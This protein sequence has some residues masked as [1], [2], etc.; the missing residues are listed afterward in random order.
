MIFIYLILP[1]I[2]ILSPILYSARYYLNLFR[3]LRLR[4]ILLSI[5]FWPVFI[6]A[7]FEYL[8][9]IIVGGE[10]LLPPT[11]LFLRNFIVSLVA[12]LVILI[13]RLISRYLRV[14][15]LPQRPEAVFFT[16]FLAGNFFYLFIAMIIFTWIPETLAIPWFS[17]LIN[18]LILVSLIVLGLI[19]VWL[20][21]HYD[22]LA[23]PR[24][25]HYLG[26]FIFLY[27]I[28]L[29][30]SMAIG[31]PGATIIGYPTLLILSLVT[32]A[33]FIKLSINIG[34]FSR[35]DRVKSLLVIGLL[36]ASIFIVTSYPLKV[37]GSI[38][39]SWNSEL[40]F[41]IDINASEFPIDV[42]NIRLVDRELA[43]DFALS[44]RLPRIGNYQLEV[45][46]SYENIGLIMGKPAWVVP[47]YY[48]YAFTPEINYM[49]GYLYIHLD[50]PTFE[51]M[52]F[53]S[54]EMIIA[55]GL[56][57]KR[58]LFFFT[59]KLVPDG[60]IG[61]IYLIDPS[62][63]TTS[64]AWVVLVDKYTS[65]G[66]R[67]P[68]KVL[69][70]GAEGDY[71]IFNWRNA[72]GLVPQVVSGAALE[73]IIGRIGV[74]IRNGEKDYFA[75]GFIWIPISQ[76]IQEYLEDE[77]YHR[78]HHFLLGNWWGRDFYLAVRTTGGEESVATWI[79]VN[80]T[81]TLFD[82][83]FYRGIGGIE[84]GVNAPEKALETME[85]IIEGKVPYGAEVRYPKL[86]RVSIGRENYLVWVALVV[87]KLPGA[88]KPIGVVWVDASNP[89]IAGFVQYVYGESHDVF[90]DRLHNNI[91]ASY[92]GWQGGNETTLVTTLINGTII[93]KNWALLQPNNEFAIIMSVE[94]ISGQIVIV[95][96]LE[97]KVATKQDF[98][99][100]VLA[101]EGDWVEIEARWDIELQAWVAYTVKLYPQEQQP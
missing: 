16:A 85:G 31:A 11:I 91:I 58:D 8:S 32:I 26:A 71:V 39:D 37:K 68:Y 21:L 7:L 87:Q 46:T 25:L 97:T 48:A 65:W 43:K 94:N 78:S 95:I 56:Y 54:K 93:R 59:L 28:T 15:I 34:L 61:E 86:Y 19:I 90:M 55:P 72:V 3:G 50:T 88:D 20:A 70:V 38:D 89:R 100:A 30:V 69:I 10:I 64:P 4:A 75:R 27:I 29:A 40:S 6:I 1:L 53:I 80:S 42:D 35:T 74:S 23:H 84:R 60:I 5:P 99:N 49:V 18:S 24:N 33:V 36:F 92:M 9:I 13:Y 66:V 44:Y 47:V 17:I 41:S 14:M 63:V 98:Y 2:I 67:V 73:S 82:L 51:S 57:G 45:G 62:P 83:R 101:K 79:L 76:D 52:R 12:L 96:V 22:I 81:L 77:F